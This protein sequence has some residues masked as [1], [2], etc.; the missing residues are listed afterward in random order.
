MGYH[1]DGGPA[2]EAAFHHPENLAFDSL[3]N[4]YVSEVEDGAR[5]QKFMPAK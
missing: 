3:G 5:I 1:G 4:L 2:S